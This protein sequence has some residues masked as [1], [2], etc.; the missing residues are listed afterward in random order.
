M[1]HHPTPSPFRALRRALSRFL[2]HDPR[3]AWAILAVSLVLTAAAWHFSAQS[4]EGRARDAFEHRVHEVHGAMEDRLLAYEQILRGGVALMEASGHVS[5]EEWRRYVES[6]AI[7]STF[8]GIQ[9]I[10][11]SQWLAPAAVA[12]HVAAVRAEGYPQYVVRPEG[13]RDGYSAIVFLEPFDARNRRAFGFDMYSEPVRRE[14][15]ARARDTGAAAMSG[16]VTLVQENGTDVQRGF[17]VYLPVYRGGAPAGTLE[18]RRAALVGWVYSPFRMKDLMRG[19]LG[20]EPRGIDFAVYDDATADAGAL[21]YATDAA[22]DRSPSEFSMRVPLA[23]AGRTWTV[24]YHG[25]DFIAAT[26]GGQ[27]AM[28][29]IGGLLIDILLFFVIASISHQKRRIEATVV[30]VRAEAEARAAELES[31]R[32]AL[33]QSRGFLDAVIDAMPNPL[34]VE[35]QTGRVVAVNDALCRFTGSAR[36]SLIGRTRTAADTGLL[37]VRTDARDAGGAAREVEDR[38]SDANGESRWMLTHERLSESPDGSRFVVAVSTDV[39]QRKRDDEALRLHDSALNASAHGA[40]IVDMLAPDQPMIYVN[41]AFEAITGYSAAESL[42][43]NPRFLHA[44][45]GVQ[46]GLTELRAAL[47]EGRG[48]QVV[49]KNYR[50]DGTPFWAEVVVS[51][52]RDGSGRVAHFVGL[53][54]D[55]TARVFAEQTLAERTQR[56]DAIFALSPDGF[57]VFERDEYLY[58]GEPRVAYVNPAFLDMTGLEPAA[59]TGRTAQELDRLLAERCDATQPYPALVDA[60]AE[61]PAGPDGDAPAPNRAIAPRLFL[62][63]PQRRILSRSV[64]VNDTGPICYF[65]DVTRETEVDRMKSEFLSTAAHELRTPMVSI[66]GFSELLLRRKYP[67]TVRHELTETIHNQAGLLVRLINELLDLARIEARAGKDFNVRRQDIRPIVEN[68]VA[69]LLVPNDPR[70]VRV[71]LPAGALDAAVDAEKLHQ[72]ITNVLSNAYKYSPD[73]GR[74][75]LEIVSGG[76][77]DRALAGIRVSDHGIGMTPEQSARAFERFYRADASGTIPGTGLG[78]CLV[79]EI[80]ELHRGRVELESAYGQGTTVTLWLP[81]AHE[82]GVARAAPALDQAA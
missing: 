43:R 1:D 38:V 17:L 52:V 36:E 37:A 44:G 14:A 35:D 50:K 9:G 63:Q 81:L 59:V 75:E 76:H 61:R 24:E 33:E 8:P 47:R 69:A 27:S 6:L 80:V 19:M 53:Q 56:V 49:L 45:D 62:A 78:L 73:G 42:G 4:V 40:L 48:T 79:K 68:A 65:R 74:I 10:G 67:D 3:L 54:T 16:A 22:S 20:R 21:L 23:R 39:S 30:R 7:G 15:M 64:R 31:A 32:G 57:V 12:A 13:P 72:A 82:E 11:F 70:Q 2:A 25:R 46:P 41:P 34:L 71:T 5:R 28:I 77:D 26:D 29:G 66:F 55:I 60:L 18:E 51:P 58:D